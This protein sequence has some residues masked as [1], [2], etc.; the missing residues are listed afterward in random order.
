M[1][2]EVF[3]KNPGYKS[4]KPLD[5]DIECNYLI[6]G[7]GVTGVFVGYFL[8]ELGA[9]NV[10]LIEKDTIGSGATGKSAGILTVKGELDFGELI[11]NYGEENGLKYWYESHE[12]MHIVK[13]IIK[14]Y[15]IDCDFEEQP[16]IYAGYSYKTAGDIVEEYEFEK[17]LPDTDIKLL[18]EDELEKLIKTKAFKFAT[19][20]H[21]HAISINPLKHVQNLSKVLDRKIKIYENT[22]LKDVNDNIAVTPNGKIKFKKIIFATDSF[23]PEDEVFALKS[24]ILV[25]KKLTKKQLE[26]IGLW[27]KKI[28]WDSKKDYDYLKVVTNSNRILFGCGHVKVHKKDRRKDPHHPH[29]VHIRKFIAE[30]YPKFEIPIEY[31]WSGIYGGTHNWHP[32]VKIEGNK[33]VAVGASSQ[34]TSVMAARYIAH[35]VLG[36]ESVLDRFFGNKNKKIKS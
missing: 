13:E 2:E 29:I 14:K 8:S 34:V 28:I 11:K 17:K 16:A 15:K 36:K 7:G 1:K 5:K 26:E 6:V 19:F 31:M 21:K 20:S 12:A 25:S 22:E 10:V 24:T 9:R 23:Y 35:K 32:F 33:F 27:P 4:R 3:W 30:L 18:T